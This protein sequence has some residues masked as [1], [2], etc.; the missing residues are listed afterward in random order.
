MTGYKAQRG[1][2]VWIDF[3]PQSGRE[4]QKRRPALVISSGSYNEK[5]HFIIVCPVTSKVKG[6]PFE[7]AIKQKGINGSILA[8]QIKSLDCVAR[9]I[10]FIEKCNQE[11]FDKTL[12]II[13]LI[14]DLHRI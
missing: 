13:A 3:D 11:S 10:E 5:S 12:K 7:V 1:D 6:Y 8:D 2:I 14:L 9:K 4:I